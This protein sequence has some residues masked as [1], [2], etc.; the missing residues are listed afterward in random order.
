MKYIKKCLISF[1]LVLLVLVQ[2]AISAFALIEK[3]ED[4]YVADYAEV[5]SEDTRNDIIAKN[6]LLYEQTGAQIVI[7]T[8]R[9]LEDGYYADEY[10]VKLFNDWGVG[11][12]SK[13]NGI[14]L[15]LVTEEGKGWLTQGSGI[16]HLLTNDD[17]NNMLE[18]YFWDKFDSGDFDGAVNSIFAQLINWYEDT[19]DFILGYGSYEEMDLG[20][21]YTGSSAGSGFLFRTMVKYMIRII[22]LIILIVIIVLVN[23]SHRVHRRARRSFW[24]TPPPPPPPGPGSG[25]MHHNPGPRPGAHR[26]APRPSR[27]SRPGGSSFGGSSFRSGG[28]GFSSGGGGG[29]SGGS[30]SGGGGRS[31]GGGAGRR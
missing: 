16:D 27:P 12:S 5:L 17:V 24:V 26:P 10:A 25:F 4:F 28:G 13:N 29:R 6:E 14:L 9:Y 8:V 15:L 22:A 19:Y 1:A 23:K 2:T 31:G 18:R 7:V 11:D 3:T 30:H 20:N 21:T